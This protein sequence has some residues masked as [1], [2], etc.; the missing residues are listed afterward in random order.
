MMPQKTLVLLLVLALAG[1][2]SS[3]PPSRFYML[4]PEIAA[5]DGGSVPI[6]VRIV[7]VGPI[8]LPRYLLRPQMVT[9]DQDNELVLDEFSR[10]GDQLDLQFGRVVS[11]NL[12]VLSAKA[13]VLQFPW[14]QDFKP[15]LR[16]V[17]D[18]TR[19][20]AQR[21]GTA[22]LR[23]RWGVVDMATGETVSVHDSSY[24][25]TVDAS[26]PGSI[27]VALSTLVA[28]FSREAATALAE[29]GRSTEAAA[30]GPGG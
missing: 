25:T 14:R 6:D 16:V 9:R 28:D 17:G 11:E 12:A 7:G 20:E 27:A 1:C 15:D 18:V 4:T 30:P 8:Q 22:E 13:A 5:A 23:L 21:S 10:W 3:T 19:F 29:A 26:D 2:V 24:R